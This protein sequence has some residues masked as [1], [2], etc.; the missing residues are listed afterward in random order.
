MAD[1][2]LTQDTLKTL[3]NYDVNSGLFTW[4]V[5]PTNSVKKGSI[6]GTPDK[7]GYV[8]IR[9]SGKLYMAHRLAWLYVYGKFPEKQIDHINHDKADNK[10]NNLRDVSNSINQINIGI[11]S[12]NTSGVKGVTF[13]RQEKKWHSFIK[14]KGRK[15]HIGSYRLFNDAVQ[16]RQITEIILGWH[17]HTG[18]LMR[19][20]TVNRKN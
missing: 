18:Q 16:A 7:Y 2:I 11:R 5:S 6:A 14:I 15:N 9:I 17:K 4:K 13:N 1:Q 8:T 3:L 10:I 12:N 19:I 20:D